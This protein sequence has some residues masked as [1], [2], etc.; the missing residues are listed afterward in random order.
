MYIDK[1]D[2]IVDECNNTYTT[3]K[4]KPIDFKYNTYINIDKEVN[5]NNANFN[6]GDHVRISLK[7]IHQ[8][9]LKKFL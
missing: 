3:I 4:R 6:V 9:G 1:L 7:A 8:T 2:D 5:D